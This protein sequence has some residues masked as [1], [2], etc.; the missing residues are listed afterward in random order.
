MTRDNKIVLAFIV[1]GLT[2]LGLAEADILK[3]IYPNRP[4][5][6]CKV[7]HCGKEKCAAACSEESMCMMRC[8]RECGR[9]R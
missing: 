8:E 4:A 1:L 7:C 3:R 2:L 9:K 5:V 6:I